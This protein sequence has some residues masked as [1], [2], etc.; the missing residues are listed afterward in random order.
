MSLITVTN[1]SENNGELTFTLA[2]VDVS[3]A[4]AIRRTIL[5]DIPVVAFKTFGEQ[6]DA[7]FTANTSRLNNEILSQ[8]L[9]CIPI[10]IST[11][12]DEYNIQ[13]LLLEVSEKNDTDTMRTITTADFKIKIISTGEYLSK[14]KCIEIFKPFISPTGESHFIQFARLRPRISPEIPGEILELTC[15]FSVGT[16]GENSMLNVVGTCAYG[17]TVD[18]AAADDAIIAQ[19]EKWRSEGLPS[20]IVNRN[21]A[22]WGFLERKRIVLPNSFDFVIATVGQLSNGEILLISCN[23]LVDKF[24]NIVQLI[25]D[26]LLTSN[27]IS[28]STIDYVLDNEDY[29]V[30]CVISSIIFNK[31]IEKKN[32]LGAKIAFCGFKKIHPHDTYSTIKLIFDEREPDSDSSSPGYAPSSSP[33]YAPGSLTKDAF[34]S[35]GLNCIK[36]SCNEAIEIFES[37][38]QIF[39]A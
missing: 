12:N 16:A 13:D 36:K 29:T 18:D 7:T 24:K 11:K 5:A 35:I 15:K 14:E 38:G 3:V 39:R 28:N 19:E 33:G 4:N 37:I 32:N 8:R 22:N 20:E 21:S 25:D 31:Y 23:I 27:P 10:N 30:G 26:G 1:T 6:S 9:S 34:R 17:M 2:G